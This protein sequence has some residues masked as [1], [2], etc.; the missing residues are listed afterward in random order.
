MRLY[1]SCALCGRRQT[2]GLLSS[3]AW[4]RVEATGDGQPRLA[5]PTCVEQNPN[6][7][8]QLAHRGDSA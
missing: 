3:A 4:G 1:L 2:G 6:W 5:C 8:E 7:R